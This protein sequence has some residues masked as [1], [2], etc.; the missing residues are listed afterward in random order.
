[1]AVKFSAFTTRTGTL[2]ASTKIVGYDDPAGTKTNVEFS[3]ATLA[4]NSG[5]YVTDGTI[6]TT[7][8]ALITDTVQFRNAG[9][10][11]DVFSL[12]TNGAFALGLGATNTSYQN[13]CI[14]ELA[15]TPSSPGCIAIGPSASAGHS[16]AA[17]IGNGATSTG[18]FSVGIGSYAAAGLGSIAIGH[19]SYSAGSY[20]INI[21]YNS[22]GSAS[23]AITLNA[24]SGAAAPSTQ[25]QYGVYMTSN[26]YPDFSVTSN[27]SKF[28]FDAD[29]FAT[30]TIADASDTTLASGETGDITIDA[31]GG[32]KI[33]ADSGAITFADGGVTLATIASLRQECFMMA[34]SDET[35]DITAT[36][37]KVRIQMPY[38]FTLTEIKASLTTAPTG[39]G[40]TTVNVYNVTDGDTVIN[41]AALS[42]AAAAIS[43]NSTSFTAGQ[44]TIAEDAVIA[45]DVAAIAGTTGGAGLKVTLIGNQTV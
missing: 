28:A 21:G 43:A 34:A 35:T 26:A 11:K 18:S 6:G 4:A 9:D 31:G 40:A 41:T 30:L 45:V 10:T 42:F 15:V 32:V 13:V 38:A 22:D 1:M 36:A 33:D 20:A 19:S 27:V 25:Y 3:L 23:N 44:E 24:S 16:Y 2:D 14:G 29:S 12:N 37:D 5:I 39:S 8:K 17:M 7:R